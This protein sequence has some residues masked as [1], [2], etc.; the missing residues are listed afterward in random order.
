MS[1]SSTLVLPAEVSIMDVEQLHAQFKGALGEEEALTISAAEVERIDSAGIQLCVSLCL[2]CQ[3]LHR[4][5]VWQDFSDTF[6]HSARLLGV[7]DVLGLSVD[8]Q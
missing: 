4:P 1:A 3:Q 2:T 7:S 8:V 5:V 6:L